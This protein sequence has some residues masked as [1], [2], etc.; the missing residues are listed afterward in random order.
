MRDFYTPTPDWFKPLVLALTASP[1]GALQLEKT[2]ENV[3][4][5][6]SNLCARACMPVRSSDLSRFANQPATEYQ[7]VGLDGRQM[8]LKQKLEDYLEFLRPLIESGTWCP[9]I[10]GRFRV[11]SPHFRGALR[12][13]MERCH[14]DRSRAE[15]LALCEHA[16]HVFGAMEI[17]SILGCEHALATLLDCLKRINSA[18]NPIERLKRKLVSS[19]MEWR[20]LEDAVK[21]LKAGA[22]SARGSDRYQALLSDLNAFTTQALRDDSSRAIVFVKMRKTAEKLCQL[23]KSTPTLANLN[24]EF[25]VGHGNGGEGMAWRGEQEVVLK[26]FKSGQ[27]KLLISTSVLEEGL[28]VPIC[29]LVIRFDSGMSLRALVQSRGRASRR[30]DS[31]FIVICVDSEEK[32]AAQEVTTQEKNM[33]VAMRNQLVKRPGSMQAQRFRCRAEPPDFSFSS[34]TEEKIDLAQEE[35]PEEYKE[36]ESAPTTS[37]GNGS[38]RKKQKYVPQIRATIVNVPVRDGKLQSQEVVQFLGQHFQ[39]QSRKAVDCSS[40]VSH[41]KMEV[42]LEPRDSEKITTKEKLWSHVVESWCSRIEGPDTSAQSTQHT[43]MWM[44]RSDTPRRKR[45]QDKPVHVLKAD[46]FVAGNLVNRARLRNHCPESHKP[47]S[48]RIAWEHDLRKMRVFFYVANNCS[49]W[50]A[51]LFQLEMQYSELEEFVLVDRRKGSTSSRVMFTLRHPPRIHKAKGFLEKDQE[52]STD[53]EDWY[54]DDDDDDENEDWGSV[55]S[56]V[57]SISSDDEDEKTKSTES[58]PPANPEDLLAKFDVTSIDAVVN[59]E[60]VSEVTG[61]G[62]EVWGRCLTYAFTLAE[63]NWP[64]A[65][66]LLSSIARFDKRVAYVPVSEFSSPDVHTNRIPSQ[67]P[68]DV[69]YAAECLLSSYPVIYDRAT[70]RFGELLTGKPEDLVIAALHKLASLLEHDKFCDPEMEME[71]LFSKPTLR[72][73]RI[74]WQLRL[75]ENC[76]YIRRLVITPTRLLYYAQEVMSKN[77][78]LRNYDPDNFICVNIRDED[79]SKLSSASGTIEELLARVKRILDEGVRPGGE[80]FLFLG[81]SN[82]QLRN[83]GCWFVRPSPH[84]NEI[85]RWMGDFSE[86]K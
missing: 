75:P 31:K 62:C 55:G 38:P 74:P 79:F 1:A 11:S 78:V 72:F 47:Q 68:F 42:T 69:K 27:T 15:G 36:L 86:I 73:S 22:L 37:E 81:S 28:D 60:R 46:R 23:L 16:M 59:W 64:D 3:D 85:R 41:G 56:E 61:M 9:G 29:N 83:H 5:L 65:K 34:G 43:Q 49:R 6:L 44:Q 13:A 52:E 8:E 58:S 50:K 48:V 63:E 35:A 53:F 7:V 77:R 32:E 54:N 66:E 17:S 25:F 71:S 39:V 24:P 30:A 14:G 2:E 12:R 80:Q 67:L 76:A 45:K 40:D 26:A 10:L 70:A 4:H 82:S 21:R 18:A 57:L 33:D 19:S 84:P 20:S 51:D